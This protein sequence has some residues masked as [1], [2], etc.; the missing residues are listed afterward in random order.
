VEYWG[1]GLVPMRFAIFPY[2]CVKYCACQ[3]K[4][5]PGHRK[6]CTCHA[7]SP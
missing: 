5:R 6:C 3:E 4:V 1:D 7:K 2:I